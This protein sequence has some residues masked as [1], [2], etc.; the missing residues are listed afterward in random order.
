MELEGPK[1]LRAGLRKYLR[2]TNERKKMSIKTI[3]QRIALVATVALG[4]GLLSIAPAHAANPIVAA[5]VDRATSGAGV[6]APCKAQASTTATT[7]DYYQVGSNIGFTIGTASNGSV[8]V[9]GPAKVVTVG[10]GGTISGSGTSAT[11]VHA[12]VATVMDVIVNITG[13][14]NITVAFIN[15][16]TSATE[17]TYYII[18]VPSCS[19]AVDLNNSRAQL[20]TSAG[21]T[22]TSS[23][24]AAGANARAYA[25]SGQYGYLDLLL[26]DALGNAV[27]DAG[28]SLVATATGGCTLSFT[29]TATSGTSVAVSSSSFTNDDLV[30]IG[31]NTPRVCNVKVSFSGT[32]VA[33]KTITMLGDVASLTID[34]AN[35]TNYLTYGGANT[36]NVNVVRYVAKDSAGNVVVPA[37]IPSIDVTSTN[38]ALQCTP[39][40]GTTTTR[41]A[42]R[43]YGYA[44][45]SLGCDNTTIRGA[46]D[47]IFKVAKSADGTSVKASKWTSTL[48]T[49]LHTFTASFD[50]ASYVSGDI[51]TLTITGKDAVG[52]LVADGTTLGSGVSVNVGGSTQL[53]ATI[54]NSTPT[55]LNGKVELKYSAGATASGY[56]WSVALP[57]NTSSQAASTGTV[58]ITAPAGGVT[59]AEVLKSIVSLIASINKQIQALQKL[60]LK[61]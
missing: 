55:F 60:I 26:V 31:D 38:G 50:K 15:G 54:S 56:G 6:N 9:T 51:M 44:T 35:S 18:A 12:D 36:V 4:M 42:A 49:G 41:S 2:P 10:A 52:N 1:D 24:D 30:I 32:E 16:D 28:N 39:A 59:N 58:N 19:G 29:N 21:D 13:A 53:T 5:N 8:S 43:T 47:F 22:A 25:I 27:A 48:S 20:N 57:A 7:P 46:A 33:N 23:I 14:G 45:L 11:I 37:A 17:E 34:A 3:K 61:R 40:D